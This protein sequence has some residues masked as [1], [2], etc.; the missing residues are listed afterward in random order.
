MRWFQWEKGRQNSGYYKM[1]IFCFYRPPVPFDLYLLKYPPGSWVPEHID[2][3][4]G[5][6]HYRANIIVKKS[7]AGGGFKSEYCLVNLS[8]LKI[9]RSDYKHEVVCVEKGVRYVLSFGVCLKIRE[10]G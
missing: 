7:L 4:E 3:V 1:C 5:Y 8:W 10:G 6:K 2:T 9:F